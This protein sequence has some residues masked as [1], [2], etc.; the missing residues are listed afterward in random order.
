MVAVD[1]EDRQ[2]DVVVWVLVVDLAVPG[3]GKPGQTASRVLAGSHSP[4]R[5]SRP[6]APSLPDAPSTPSRS[7]T[8]P[9][10]LGGRRQRTGRALAMEVRRLVAHHLQLDLPV[11]EAVVAQSLHAALQR[12]ARR[13]VVVE[14]VAREQDHVDLRCVATRCLGACSAPVY[15]GRCL[16]A[17]LR[18][19]TTSTSGPG[20]GGGG[21]G[22][23]CA[24]WQ[25][26]RPH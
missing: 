7:S 1:G 22:A 11:P 16:E 24:R 9:A 20:P 17:P 4:A 2:L 14:E 21:V 8:P 5:L 23:P 3:R 13:L 15:R 19:G 25:S 6:L 26:E 18:E 12:L 10:P